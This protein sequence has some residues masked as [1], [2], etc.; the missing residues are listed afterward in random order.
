[1]SK[2][3]TLS[4]H[5]SWWSHTLIGDNGLGFLSQAI[6]LVFDF[7]CIWIRRELESMG[8]EIDLCQLDHLHQGRVCQRQQD[9]V[10]AV[11]KD[12]GVGTVDIAAIAA[13]LEN[14]KEFI[15]IIQ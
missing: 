8:G 12:S 9:V 5:G 3:A 10:V 14:V 4:T 6:H 7:F 15:R 1:M 13:I 2:W 11:A